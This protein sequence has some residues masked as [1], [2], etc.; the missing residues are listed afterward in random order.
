MPTT[1]S[2]LDIYMSL[3]NPEPFISPPPSENNTHYFVFPPILCVYS[4]STSIRLLPT[5]AELPT[6]L[7]SLQQQ[8]VEAE[9]ALAPYR[10]NNNAEAPL[11]DEELAA[12]DVG[13]AHW[14]AEWKKR[15]MWFTGLVS[16][17]LHLS[18][19]RPAHNQPKPP[20]PSPLRA[21]FTHPTTIAPKRPL[22]IEPDY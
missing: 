16:D 4:E 19:P 22:F 12:L 5:N 11:T 14:R 7:S 8:L 3:L 20:L 18:H 17:S 13:W 1:D 9:A 10:A 2:N 6:L 21:I 15:K